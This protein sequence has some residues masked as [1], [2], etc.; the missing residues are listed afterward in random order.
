MSNKSIYTELIKE[1]DAYF[2]RGKSYDVRQISGQAKAAIES[3]EIQ[4][5]KLEAE[6]GRHDAAKCIAET[7]IIKLEEDLRKAHG[8]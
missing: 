1:L 4:I 8:F 5:A 2:K 6:T 7:R 3:L